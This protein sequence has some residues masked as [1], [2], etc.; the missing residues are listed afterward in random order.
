MNKRSSHRDQKRGYGNDGF[1]NRPG[2]NGLR[3]AH[4]EI[5]LDQP[6]S[7]I[8]DMGKDERAGAGRDGQELVLIFPDGSHTVLMETADYSGSP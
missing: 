1:A 6:E 2:L 8:V 5:L 7:S 3:D 4:I